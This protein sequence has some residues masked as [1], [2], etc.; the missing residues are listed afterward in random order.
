M[1][2]VFFLS[3]EI[4]L[5]TVAF[6]TLF[7]YVDSTY[8]SVLTRIGLESGFVHIYE[9]ALSLGILITVGLLIMFY[10]VIGLVANQTFDLKSEINST[11]RRLDV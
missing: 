5:L 7:L 3:F 4:V 10:Q 8:V 2:K 1:K 6:S 9:S 11:R